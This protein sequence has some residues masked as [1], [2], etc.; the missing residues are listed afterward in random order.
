[1]RG[2]LV[3]VLDVLEWLH[4]R[5]AWASLA[6]RARGEATAAADPRGRM[7]RAEWRALAHAAAGRPGRHTPQRKATAVV[8]L[9]PAMGDGE[10]KSAR[11]A[12]YEVVEPLGTSDPVGHW[13]AVA[14]AVAA[15]SAEV[16][17]LP[18]RGARVG[19]PW[20]GELVAALE[21]SRVAAVIGAG[22]TDID[23][24]A[25]L[26]LFGREALRARYSGAG[27]PPQFIALR[28]DLYEAVGE[29]EPEVAR[30]GW[31]APLLDYVDRALDVGLTVARLDTH[32]ITPAG[33]HR[34]A[35]SVAEW[36]RSWARGAL[37]AARARSIGGLR[38]VHAFAFGGMLPLLRF[39][40]PDRTGRKSLR[41]TAGSMAAFLG[42]AAAALRTPQ[43][44][45]GRDV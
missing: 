13:R 2:A 16:V 33:I 41:H 11:A 8:V 18:L 38:G 22:L 35:R 40:R 9:G 45:G 10:R 23:P 6:V 44:P 24:P 32:G 25:V 1:M 37:H 43:P 39:R 28:R 4:F 27:S 20:L 31:M 3:V 30:L 21:G 5:G 36:H 19:E 14:D 42:G 26:G 7:P 12:G 29:I 34:P 17:A 15:S